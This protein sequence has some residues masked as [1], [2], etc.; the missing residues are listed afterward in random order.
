MKKYRYIFIL[1]FLSLIS[2]VAISQNVR[3]TGKVNEPKALIRLLTYNDMLTYEQTLAFETNADEQGNFV[4]ETDID[5]IVM[6]QLAVNLERVDFLIKPEAIYN[7][8]IIIPE[9]KKNV[10]YFEK[11]SPELK[12]ID[13][14]DDDLFYQYYVSDM[15]VDDFLL[16]NFNQLYKS[17][18]ISLLDSLDVEIERNL[19]K[20]KS[21]FVKDNIR[22]RKAAIQM[23]VNNDN[24]KKVVNQYYNKQNVLYSNPAYMDLFQEIFTNYFAS[25]SFN[26]LEL[27]QMLY[28]DYDKFMSYLKGK[29]V[30]LAEN[31]NLAEII[32]A[33]NLKGMFY[34]LA[35]DR[36][37]ILE[38]LKSIGQNS[39]NQKNK[40]I[41]D[42]ILKQINRLSFNSDA[43]DF[44]LKDKNGKIVKLS[45]YKDNMLLLQFV[46]EVSTMT[47][48]QFELLKDF[49]NQWQDTIQVVTIATKESFDDFNRLFENKNYKWTLLNLDNEILLLEK[50]QIRLFPDYVII[51]KNGKIGMSPAPSPE[52]Y[53]DFH[54]RRLYKYYKK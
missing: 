27:E 52:Q 28:A 22:Y 44:S 26:Q 53:L 35:E 42:D 18:K 46:N 47:D 40:E 25:R 15:I 49:S 54:V 36:M 16:N 5:K 34:E 31:P 7:I 24:A 38:K 10:S 33:Y 8:E 30:F 51:G 37:A 17:R 2:N 11:E 41:V 32:V 9:Q 3:I 13:I 29:D 1:I 6:V 48:Y 12:I 50:Y 21:D 45:D 39:N 23:V 20:I 14:N 43:P 19:G 4:I